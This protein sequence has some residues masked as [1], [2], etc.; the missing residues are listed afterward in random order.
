MVIFECSAALV[1]QCGEATWQG[2]TSGR[3]FG[4][5]LQER[6]FETRMIGWK[7]HGRIN[8]IVAAN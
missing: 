6:L 4:G 5:K 8:T 2:R 7:I 1:I 3:R